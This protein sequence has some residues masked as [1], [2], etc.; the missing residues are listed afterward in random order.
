MG[1]RLARMPAKE[2]R[3]YA[4]NPLLRK[5]LSDPG[6]PRHRA[7]LPRTSGIRVFRVWCRQWTDTVRS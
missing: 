4:I 1:K 7:I 5:T 3:V 6:V 2:P